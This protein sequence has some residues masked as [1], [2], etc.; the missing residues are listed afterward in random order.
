M[1]PLRR[2]QQPAGQSIIVPPALPYFS[3]FFPQGLTISAREQTE[4]IISD[5]IPSRIESRNVSAHLCLAR[6]YE[7]AADDS[8]SAPYV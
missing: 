2:I 3:P 8:A 1:P 6:L 4:G 7:L 5:V